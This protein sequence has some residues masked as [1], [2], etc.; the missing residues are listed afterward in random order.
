MRYGRYFWLMTGLTC[1]MLVLMV[2]SLRVGH[3]VIPFA[4]VAAALFSGDDGASSIIVREIRIPRTFLA[5]FIGAMLAVSGAVLQGLF[6]NPL[7]EP[8]IIGVGAAASLGAVI[9]I[10]SG[11]SASFFLALPLMAQTGALLAVFV[12]YQLSGRQ[13][14]TLTLILAGVALTS[15]ASAVT[16]LVLNMS[17]NPYAAMEIVFWMMG[18]L[19]DRSMDHVWLSVPFIIISLLMLF[20]T[21][22]ALYALSLGEDVAQSLGVSLPRTRF[23]A[24]VGTA[25]GVGAATAVAGMIGFIGL[26]V[27]HLLR[28]LVGHH[29]VAL[30]PASALGGACF[31]LMADIVTRMIFINRDL[32]LGVVTALVGAP[33]FLWLLI[34]SRRT[35]WS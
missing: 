21:A 11:L 2:F 25:L 15:M 20:M 9:A 1:L 22:K 7:A 13:A 32:K 30:L 23:L 6:R 14:S 33:F 12:L 19:Q 27:P 18:S 16:S 10:Y 3:V 4:E 35:V 28:P 24:I 26:V 31:L 29:P 34:K 5:V 17:A 8:G